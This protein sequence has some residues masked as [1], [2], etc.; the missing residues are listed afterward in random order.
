MKPIINGM[1][2]MKKVNTNKV[3]GINIPINAVNA[4]NNRVNADNNRVIGSGNVL[5]NPLSNV[6]D[7][8]MIKELKSRGFEVC[9][10]KDDAWK[11]EE[12]KWEDWDD[13]EWK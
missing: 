11:W 4:D 8:E 2:L 5:G 10:W 9:K 13:A 6:P 1:I 7:E 3:N 12:D